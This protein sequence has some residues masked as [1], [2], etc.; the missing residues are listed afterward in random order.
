MIE[1]SS[2]G[3]YLRNNKNSNAGNLGGETLGHNIG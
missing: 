1:I 3:I 2:K